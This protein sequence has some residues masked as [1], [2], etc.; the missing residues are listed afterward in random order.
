MDGARLQVLS[1][2]YPILLFHFL[3]LGSPASEATYLLCYVFEPFP[4]ETNPKPVAL[5]AEP[6]ADSATPSGIAYFPEV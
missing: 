5:G 6:L 4:C 2:P 1:L 3:L